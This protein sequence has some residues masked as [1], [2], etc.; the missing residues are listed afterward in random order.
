MPLN[1]AGS[2]K[3]QMQETDTIK[4]TSWRQGRRP[5]LA[6]STG[7]S[8][9]ELQQWL[10]KGFRNP[11]PTGPATPSG[12]MGHMCEKPSPNLGYP[13]CFSLLLLTHMGPK[14]ESMKCRWAGP[15]PPLLYKPGPGEY[16]PL[17]LE[18]L[19]PALAQ[20]RSPGSLAAPDP[21]CE[22]LGPGHREQRLP[23]LLLS[24]PGSPG[25]DRPPDLCLSWSL[26][27]C[28]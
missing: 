13:R 22:L 12:G 10:G 20:R 11:E 3:G 5:G 26:W 23:F 25:L 14:N 2:P 28:C 6:L 27:A 4:V 21:S 15:L 17:S 8:R 19:L 18:C 7:G 16:P 9:L 1:G 24:R